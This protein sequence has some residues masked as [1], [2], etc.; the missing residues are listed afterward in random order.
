MRSLHRKVLFGVGCFDGE[1]ASGYMEQDLM[2]KMGRSLIDDEG[3]T[4]SGMDISSVHTNTMIHRGAVS[5]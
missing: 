2:L 4:V 3:F 1:C 5:T